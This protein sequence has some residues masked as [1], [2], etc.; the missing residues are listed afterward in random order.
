MLFSNTPGCARNFLDRF[1][2][3]AAE[4]DIM[5]AVERRDAAGRARKQSSKQP[6]PTPKSA[7]CAKRSFDLAMSLKSTSFL[8]AA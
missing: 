6:A 5:R 2:I 1:G 3:D 8:S 7:S 4:H